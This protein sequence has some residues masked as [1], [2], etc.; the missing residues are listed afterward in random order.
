MVVIAGLSLLVLSLLQ[1]ASAGD[2]QE[3][4]PGQVAESTA[5]PVYAVEL[6]G[7]LSETWSS[8]LRRAQL[9]ARSNKAAHL[10]IIIDSP[11]GEIELMKRLGDRIDEIAREIPTT[12]LI[13]REALSAAAYL[14]ISSERIL[15]CPASSIGAAMPILVGPGGVMPE[16][17][18]DLREKMNSAFRAEFRSWA[19]VHQ[20]DGRIAEAF[21]DSGIELK[22]VNVRGEQLLV[23]GREFEDLLQ[24][25]ETPHFLETLCASGELLTLT[26]SQALE[27]AYCD[28]V[29][30]DQS[31]ALLWLGL[32][33]SPLV[34]VAPNWSESLVDAIGSWSWLLMLAGAFFMVVSFNMPGLGAPEMAALAC[35]GVFMFHGHLIG[36]AEWTEVLLVVGGSLL[37]A[38]EIF[39][40]PG[41]I[42]AGAAGG[43]MLLAGLVLS[44][45]D[46]VLPDGAI[47]STTLRHNFTL[48]LSVL[49]GAP[50]LALLAVRRLVNSRAG[51][52]L[53]TAPDPAFAGLQT[54]DIAVG[55]RAVCLT[56]LRPSGVITI[57]NIRY[58][59]LSSG[60]FIESGAAVRVV[61]KSGAA[62]LVEAAV[63]VKKEP[64][65]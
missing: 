20:R 53:S 63:N 49:L 10:L 24:K 7:P 36:L 59:A 41:T 8:I 11:G 14:A 34:M 43:V 50:M 37:I 4:A 38:V 21:V 25:G 57:E 31:A 16:I 15:M 28:A 65:Q 52:T 45:Q 13:D 33:D 48:V 2:V 60:D 27:F 29:V 3:S 5:H 56:A 22:K 54:P 1:N 39:V 18:D 55:S 44:M 58:D 47:E 64:T 32:A 17:D 23:N 30:A 46:F 61:G 51:S 19:E 62:L 26:S 9:L 42:F 35:I 12:C 40:I 6:R